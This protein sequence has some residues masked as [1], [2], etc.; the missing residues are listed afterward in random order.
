M[1]KISDLL[2]VKCHLLLIRLLFLKIERE[3]SETL[4]RLIDSKAMTVCNVCYL[5]N[6]TRNEA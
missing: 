2:S 3:I 5:K 1:G 4:S 6:V